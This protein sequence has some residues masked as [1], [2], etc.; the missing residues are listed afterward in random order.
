MSLARWTFVLSLLFASA[1][2]AQE[3]ACNVHDL[4]DAIDGSERACPLPRGVFGPQT[5]ALLSTAHEKPLKEVR[6]ALLALATRLRIEIAPGGDDL[7]ARVEQAVEP[8]GQGLHR[9]GFA[10]ISFPGRDPD[11]TGCGCAWVTGRPY[12]PPG[13]R[14]CYRVAPAEQATCSVPVRTF[15]SWTDAAPTFLA[16]RLLHGGLERLNSPERAK[17]LS[18]LLAAKE[19]WRQLR[20]N[21][22][23]QYPWEL[24]SSLALP[25]YRDY[26][27]CF[28]ADGS[29][30]GAEGL[31][32]ER[33][34]LIFLHPSVGLAFQGF[35]K[36]G[37]PSAD[38]EAALD[39]EVA[40]VNLYADSFK[41]YVGA[42][43]A[44]GFVGADF[45][46]PRIGPMLHV[47]RWV[48]VG[49]LWCVA[50]DARKDASI[51]TSFDVASWFSKLTGKSFLPD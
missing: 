42:S 11:V 30:T 27:A 28:L 38:A 4:I 14:V 12:D 19:K 21:G 37:D 9:S 46:Q 43:V 33:V 16:L 20:D 39:I 47:T 24:F 35:G 45:A 6:A 26:Q 31:S 29:C 13:E 32:P 49:Y 3:A 10:D 23:V 48:H 7:A 50:G 22:Y 1:G 8:D 36:K 18:A 5:E 44:A 51:V 2:Q 34:R 17:A 25:R 41:W 40:G 15:S